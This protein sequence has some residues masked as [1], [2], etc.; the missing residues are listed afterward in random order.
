MNNNGTKQI[1]N[2][3]I[4]GY[5]RYKNDTKMTPAK[6]LNIA[7]MEMIEGFFKITVQK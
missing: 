7:I 3:T 4:M 1:K 5:D 2:S 6:L